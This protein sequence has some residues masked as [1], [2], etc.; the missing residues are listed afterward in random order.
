MKIIL[1]EDQFDEVV[2]IGTY[3]GKFF[4]YWDKFGP[5]YDDKMLKLFGL[6]RGTIPTGIVYSWLREYLG[7]DSEKEIKEFLNKKVHTIDNCGGYDFTFTINEYEKDN[8][9][10]EI[11]LTVDDIDGTVDLIMTGGGEHTLNDAMASYEYGWEIEN[12]IEECLWDY[13]VEN[14]ENKT[15]YMFVFK[16]INY[17]S[18]L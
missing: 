11:T 1:T 6:S 4:K 14:V 15:G 2:E 12:E 16:K 5:K 17:R 10:I 18:F 9:Q 7:T 3:K 13:M 8:H